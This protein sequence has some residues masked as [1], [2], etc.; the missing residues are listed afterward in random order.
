MKSIAAGINKE[1]RK[2]MII[3]CVIR[4]IVLAVLSFERCQQYIV[5]GAL[6]FLQTA[7]QTEDGRLRNLNMSCTLHMATRHY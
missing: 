4:I 7:E 3:N 5:T 1:V 2:R 6:N